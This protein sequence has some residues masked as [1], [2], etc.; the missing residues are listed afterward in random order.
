MQQE[1][2]ALSLDE[3][4]GQC[5][6]V[7]FVSTTPSQEIIDLIQ[8][9]HVGGI[10]FFSR[11]VA[12]AQ[13]VLDLTR[14]LQR[15]AR[16]AD[17]RL[18]LLIAIDQENGM[19][20]RLHD[21]GTQ[22]PG[23]M[24]LGAV[25]SEKLAQ[26]VATATGRELRALGINMNLAPVVDVNNNPANP[27]IGTRS[28]GE[29]PRLVARLGAAQVQGYRAAGVIAT[30]KHFPGHG[31]TAV[32]SHLAL[33]VVPYDMQR[34]EQI[35]L[36]PFRRCIEAEADCV[37]TAHV[38]FPTITGD[39][40]TPATLS[41]AVVNDLLRAHLGFNGVVI[42]DCLEM[43]AVRDTVGVA[44][45]SVMALQ[46]G[47]DLVLISHHYDLQCAGIEAVRAALQS[48]E[49]SIEVVRQAAERVLRLKQK[50][51]SWDDPAL[52]DSATVP[53]L[54]GDKAHQRLRDHVY[55]LS[56]TLVKNEDGLV[57]LRLQP[58]QEIL[59]LIPQ[60]AH[61]SQA[62]DKQYPSD[63]LVESIRRYHANVKA[64]AIPPQPSLHEM[65]AMQEAIHHADITIM[66]TVNAQ[67]DPYQPI[68]MN[69]L[70]QKSKRVVGLAIGSPYDLLA[71]SQLRTYLATYEYTRPALLAATRVLFGWV[72]PQG[73]LPVTLQ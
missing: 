32:D 57:P 25:N 13:Q 60:N 15:L 7:G 35:E 34:L 64:I 37:M 51:L 73:H 16:Q 3:L 62:E 23:G 58:E 4:I 14:H 20:Q 19:V 49:L 68:L 18:P 67:R 8:H 55:A 1:T 26:E 31:D 66:M 38:V 33:P 56:T 45:G 9:Y 21:G 24:A 6:I 63:A 10:I 30:L 61:G 41:P 59:V 44:R 43:S 48:G 28:F 52:A 27:V 65:M 39:E 29:D 71:F 17:Q 72:H 69:Y 5:F 47:I 70:L 42:S 12:D 54:V 2:A 50:R 53:A 40:T 22:F 11:N 46:A 36:V